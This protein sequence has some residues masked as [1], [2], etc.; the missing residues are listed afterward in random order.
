MALN[1]RRPREV[2]DGPLTLAAPYDMN[3]KAWDLALSDH[4]TSAVEGLAEHERRVI[5][6]GYFEEH[7]HVEVARTTTLHVTLV[8]TK[9]GNQTKTPSDK[10]L[11]TN[12]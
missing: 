3:N 10:S 4:V 1:T 12:K 8:E 11:A 9:R 6:P 2:R 7:T 5:E